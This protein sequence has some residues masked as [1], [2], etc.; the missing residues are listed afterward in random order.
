MKQGRQGLFILVSIISCVLAALVLSCASPQA[1]KPAADTAPVPTEAS[2]PAAGD[3]G[4][5]AD[6]G[7]SEEFPGP[8]EDS[9][10]EASGD[11]LGVVMSGGDENVGGPLK[12]GITFK[13][14]P[15]TW[16]PGAGWKLAWADEFK[17]PA[18]DPA[19]WNYEL[20]YA[21]GWGNGEFQEYVADKDVI[22]IVGGKLVIRQLKEFD[23]PKG[24]RSARITTKDKVDFKFGKI[25]V[26]ARLPYSQ[27]LWPAFWLLG[28][29]FPKDSAWPGC[30][31]IDVMEMKGGGAGRDDSIQGTLHW[32]D[33]S[34]DHASTTAF[35]TLPDGAYYCEDFH[36][37]EVEWSPSEMVWKVDGV[38]YARKDISPA[39]MDE[40]RK[41]FFFIMNVA[42]GGR[43]SGYPDENSVFP[44][45]MEIDWVRYYKR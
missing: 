6:A 3:S 34:G 8:A 20:G 25:A 16:A 21:E 22:E 23:G 38:E 7:A 41:P 24:Y 11:F 44:Q 35:R 28:T 14:S 1:V 27:G 37:F 10:D 29:G 26:R 32:G 40:F 31:E 18:L 36:V 5:V 12:E 45:K 9:E 2:A 4:S 43:F 15:D 19:Y 30:G 42:V 39:D 13:S 17:G 33:E